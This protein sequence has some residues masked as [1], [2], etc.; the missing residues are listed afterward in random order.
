MLS[1]RQLCAFH[2]CTLSNLQLPKTKP[3]EHCRAEVV[4]FNFGLSP[5]ALSPACSSGTRAGA[6]GVRNNSEFDED[7]D[8]REYLRTARQE[9]RRNTDFS[10]VCCSMSFPFS[11]F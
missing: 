7:D 1:V 8:L 2:L 3:S 10:Q 11:E 5:I 6:G 4:I 9:H